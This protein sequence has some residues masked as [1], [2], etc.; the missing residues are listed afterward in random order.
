MYICGLE[1]QDIV[2]DAF[3][4]EIELLADH[5]VLGIVAHE[6]AKLFVELEQLFLQFL[7]LGAHRK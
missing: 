4:E 6:D 1:H 5:C 3:D 7:N 2:L